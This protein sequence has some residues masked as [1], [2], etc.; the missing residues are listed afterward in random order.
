MF[1]EANIKGFCHRSFFEDPYEPTNHF[2]SWT[3]PKIWV[4]LGVA[5]SFVCVCV[6]LTF[7]FAEVQIYKKD[8]KRYNQNLG[9]GVLIRPPGT[10]PTR[11]AGV[12][13]NAP[14]FYNQIHSL[15]LT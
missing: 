11:N 14:I 8:S 7:F 6:C 4:G 2:T 3:F 13:S 9:G 1:F 15:K 5:T 12:S 10:R